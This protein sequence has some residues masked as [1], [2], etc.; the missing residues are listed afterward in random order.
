MLTIEY[1]AETTTIRDWETLLKN[2]VVAYK[3]EE[4]NTLQHPVLTEDDATAT[5]EKEITAYLKNLKKSVDDWRAP[6]CGI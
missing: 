2:L 1:P 4:V 6:G 5:G 3:L